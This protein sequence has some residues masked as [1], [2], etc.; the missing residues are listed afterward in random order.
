MA[1]SSVDEKLGKIKTGYKA[2]LISLDVESLR[3]LSGDIS[4]NAIIE[5]TSGSMVKD[6]IINGEFV[7]KDRELLTIDEERLKNTIHSSCH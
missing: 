5:V 6:S 1:V 2:D 4:K 3:Y 7:M